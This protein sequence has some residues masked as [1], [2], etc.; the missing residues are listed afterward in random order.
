MNK[1]T[2]KIVIWAT[3]ILAAVILIIVLKNL[4]AFVD[5]YS[6]GRSVGE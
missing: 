3:V 5:G 4:D 1:Q 2:K 6:A